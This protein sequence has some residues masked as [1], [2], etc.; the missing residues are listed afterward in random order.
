VSKSIGQ[1]M[2]IPFLKCSIIYASVL[3]WLASNDILAFQ[4]FKEEKI[5]EGTFILWNIF[6]FALFS[7]MRV[8]VGGNK[9]MILIHKKEKG[10]KVW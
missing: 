9:I 2:R 10:N 7:T 5:I 6:A 8:I 1:E 4:G 3:N